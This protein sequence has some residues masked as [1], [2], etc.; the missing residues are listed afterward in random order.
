[1]ILDVQKKS[2]LELSCKIILDRVKHNV[3]TDVDYKFKAQCA[4]VTSEHSS[5]NISIQDQYKVCS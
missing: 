2:S 1:M 5:L 4:L 3:E